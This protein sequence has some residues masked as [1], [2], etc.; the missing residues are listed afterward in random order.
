MWQESPGWSVLPWQ[1]WKPPKS[2]AAP[3]AIERVCG[4]E[5]TLVTVTCW[6]ADVSPTCTRPNSNRVGE[7]RNVDLGIVPNGIP[8]P[9]KSN[10]NGWP[11]IEP[12]VLPVTVPLASGLNW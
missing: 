12:D 11:L 4:E 2:P 6:F 8:V 7:M 9:E 3:P 1:S 10:A 5:L